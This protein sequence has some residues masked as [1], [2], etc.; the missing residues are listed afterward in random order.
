[1]GNESSYASQSLHTEA[2]LKQ[3]A[4]K[5]KLKL[6]E[7]KYLL[8]KFM[9]VSS[10]I[11]N[12]GIIDIKE[13]QEALGLKSQKL[14]SY[15]FSAF[16]ADRNKK[17]DFEEFVRGLSILSFNATIKESAKFYF[18][19]F[20]INKD[21]FITKDELRKIIKYSLIQNDHVQLTKMQIRKIV[22]LTFHKIG[23]DN[24][25]MIS[26]DEFLVYVSEAPAIFNFVK[27][28]L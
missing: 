18:D 22:D 1:M 5:N 10:L 16:D 19:I 13:F 9:S 24:D 20:D 27:F 8:D 2:K 7:V 6:E 25:D 3:I 15:I 28:I 21:G 26:F 23:K 14:A 12:D 11:V 17:I 4:T